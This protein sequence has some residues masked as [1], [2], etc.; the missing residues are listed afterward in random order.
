VAKHLSF[1]ALSGSLLAFASGFAACSGGS[2]ST[3]S[4][5]TETEGEGGTSSAGGSSAG[6]SGGTG[7][8]ASGGTSAAGSG[9]IGGGTGG[10]SAAGTSGGNT[11]PG[12]NSAAGGNGTAGSPAAGGSSSGGTETAGGNAGTSAATEGPGGAA[13]TGS[14]GEGGASAGTGG[15]STGTAGTT[16][17]NMVRFAAIGDVGH[18]NDTQKAVA[19]AVK[20]KCAASGCDFVVLLGDNFY[21]NGVSGTDDAQWNDTFEA[22][23][24]GIDLPFYAVLGNHDYGGNGAG[25]EPQK[26]DYQVAYTAVSP[27]QRWK[28]PAKHYH[29]IAGPAE[30]FV[31]DTNEQMFGADGQ[32][33][34]DVSGWLG[35]STAPWR[36]ALGHHPYLSNGPHGNAGTYEGIPFIPVVSGSGVKS[37]M[38]DVVCGKVDIYLS[39][40]D[41]SRQW[42]K[43]TCNGSQLIVNGAGSGTTDL[44]SKNEVLFQEAVAGFLYVAAEPNTLSAEFIADDGAVE[45]TQTLTKLAQRTG[46][47]AFHQ[48]GRPRSRWKWSRWAASQ[49]GPSTRERFVSSRSRSSTRSRNSASSVSSSPFRRP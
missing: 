30:L 49:R 4:G 15:T 11:G 20:E 41:H 3:A 14:A 10:S 38:E 12:G 18:A 47:A 24:A 44:S 33:R 22:I 45:F 23:Y 7:G 32:Q 46:S 13:G 35:G 39:G 42:L 1:L 27:T 26:A 25:Y 21:S 36:I 9:G 43:P 34:T 17:S 2:S 16:A 28:M 48:P 40:H 37:F 31:L 19:A 29:F 5:F 6:G 8:K